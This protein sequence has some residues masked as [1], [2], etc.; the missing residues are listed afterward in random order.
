MQ[1]AS[2]FGMAEPMPEDKVRVYPDRGQVR[3]RA[4]LRG[5]GQACTLRNS[6]SS[7]NSK[8]GSRPD[9]ENGARSRAHQA[10]LINYLN[11]SFDYG[12]RVLATL[13]ERTRPRR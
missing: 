10:E 1:K 7:T 13:T 8:A 9:C 11:D 5:A 12:N 6:P 2:F 4:Q 3:G